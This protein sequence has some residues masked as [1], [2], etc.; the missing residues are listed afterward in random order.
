M[1]ILVLRRA[2]VKRDFKLLE[3]V[4]PG[5]TLDKK[6]LSRDEQKSLR[7]YLDAIDISSYDFIFF[8]LKW[9][10]IYKQLSFIKTLPNLVIYEWDAVQN[11]MPESR[12][13]KSFQKFYR[14]LPYQRIIST[15]FGVSSRLST[16]GI[17]SH[18]IPKYFDET[19]ISNNRTDRDI[20]YAFVGSI[21][22]KIYR[23]RSEL[24]SSM[25][26]KIKLTITSTTSSEDYN[27]LLNKIR[28]FISADIGIDEY[29][30]K[31]FE[32]LAAGCI[33]V[34]YTIPSEVD[35]LG[36][37]DMENVI[38]YTS[39]DEAIDKIALVE[40]DTALLNKIATQGQQLAESRFTLE[41]HD[42]SIFNYLSNIKKKPIPVS[43]YSFREKMSAFYY[44]FIA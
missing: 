8:D 42:E 37:K 38:L 24:L 28:F 19:N 31:N 15:G 21:D 30:M 1:K 44:D 11:F 35:A 23:Q 32:A 33:L 14:K 26:E 34:C 7:N 18:T 27:K 12:Y 40:N 9:S 22:S 13:Y 20:D 16:L 2:D 41:K 43:S 10:L 4:P 6:H 3:H 17:N 29:M 39:V 25:A 36:F 5:V